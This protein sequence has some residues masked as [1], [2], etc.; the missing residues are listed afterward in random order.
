M[1]YIVSYKALKWQK[2]Y[3]KQMSLQWEIDF[4]WET[5]FNTV[6]KISPLDKKA[7]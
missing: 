7:R 1:C 5:P 2:P 3:L 6:Y 4:P